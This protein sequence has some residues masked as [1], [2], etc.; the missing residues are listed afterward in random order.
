M[1]SSFAHVIGYVGA[2]SKS[3]ALADAVLEVPGFSVG[4]FGVEKGYEASLRGRSGN[5]QVEVNAH[6]RVIRELQRDEGVSGNDISL[7]LDAALQEFVA[8]RL[9]AESASATLIDVKTGECLAMVSTPSFDPN[10]FVE[11]FSER[12]WKDIIG[13]RRSPL[14]NKAVS[15]LYPP[16]SVFKLVVAAAALEYGV[17]DPRFEVNCEGYVQLGN[18]AFHCWK[19]GGHGTLSLSQA[20]AQSCD[21][22]FYNLALKVGVRRVAE[23]ARKLGLGELLSLIHI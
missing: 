18:R 5:I 9:G 20:I 2:A 14:S 3:D 17:S 22:Y 7:T 19:K 8:Q 11:G 6:G 1:G 15:G 10:I 16:G 13:N 23:M 4:K 12:Q 21:V